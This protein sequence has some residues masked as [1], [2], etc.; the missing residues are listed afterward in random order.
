[1]NIDD[2]ILACEA[3]I[4]QAQ[5]SSDVAA[6]DRLLDDALLFTAIDGTLA[7]KADD[8]ALHGSGKL[9]VTK[10]EPIDRQVLHLGATSVVSVLM[11]A[12]AVVNGAPTAGM[13]RYTRVWHK[14]PDGWRVVAGHMSSVPAN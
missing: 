5:L 14:R 7:T 6:L 1:M 4:R 12:A 2:E 8:L 13:L 11:D 10:M 9:L 3:E